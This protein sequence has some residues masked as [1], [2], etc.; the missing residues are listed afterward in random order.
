MKT[1][2]LLLAVLGNYFSYMP[3][4]FSDLTVTAPV[5]QQAAAAN[6][7]ELTRKQEFDAALA[8]KADTADMETALADKADTADVDASLAEKLAKASNLGDLE[9]AGAARGNLELGTAAVEDIGTGVGEVVVGGDPRLEDSRTP[10]DHADSHKAGGGDELLLNEMGLPDG[11]VAMNGQ[12]LTGLADPIAAQDGTTVAWVQSQDFN[13]P[14]KASARVA[15]LGNITLAGLG[16]L[17]GV[18]LAEGDRVLTMG[19]TVKSQNG[20][21]LA[22][23]GAW[24]R[25]TDADTSAKFSK[26]MIVRINEGT[27]LAGNF[28]S[29]KTTGLIT[30]GTTLLEF[31]Q[32]SGTG[33]ILAGA[34]IS[35]SGNTISVTDAGITDAKIG[36][37]TVDD[38]LATPASTGPLSSLLS[39]I[40]GRIKAI[41]GTTHWYDAP[42][43][44]LAEADAAITTVTDDLDAYITSN[45]AAMAGK[46]GAN[47]EDVSTVNA[48][49][50]LGL[51]TAAGAD[52]GTADGEVVVG[53][54]TRLTDSRTPTAH[55]ESHKLD[56]DD[57]ILL[58]EMGL[59]TAPVAMNSQKITG[60]ADG[61]N[62]QDGA[63]VNNVQEVRDEVGFR[64]VRLISTGNLALT[65]LVAV[66]GVTPAA[67]ELVGAIN[68]T[69]AHQNG[70]YIVG[71][72]AWV[73]TGDT[74]KAGLTLRATEG[75]VNAG[76]SFRVTTNGPITVG[77][78]A[79][80]F[81]ENEGPGI[82][83][84]RAGGL[85]S[86]L[87][88]AGGQVVVD[89]IYGDDSTGARGRHD[90]PFLTLTAAKAASVAG[91]WI[92]VGPGL[93]NETDLA[94]DQVNWFF[95]PG[96]VVDYSGASIVGI[97]ESTTTLA[98]KVRGNGE[99]IHRAWHTININGATAGASTADIECESILATVAGGVG[100]LL[101][102]TGNVRVKCRTISAPGAGGAGVYGGHGIVNIEAESITGYSKGVYMLGSLA[103]VWTIKADTIAAT[104]SA[105]GASASL[106]GGTLIVTARELLKAVKVGGLGAACS[107]TINGARIVETSV[108][109]PAISMVAAPAL[110]VLKD[111]ILVSAAA[112]SIDSTA[113]TNVKVYGTC[114]ANV[115]KGSNITEIV[116]TIEVDVD[117]N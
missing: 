12:R 74:L 30:L 45:D 60:L 69:T 5:V 1:L 9:D 104:T 62:P 28:Y 44:T 55:A 23:A 97:F 113:A 94:K 102:T 39:W 56:G 110:T 106:F 2:T 103:D 27:T 35:K 3:N 15:A 58:S 26:G 36:D 61:E 37:R 67:G 86:S 75:T 54:D 79:V 70:P 83:I 32:F 22:S 80:A 13:G 11:P 57:E 40:A 76:R 114:N 48:W 98:F 16:T 87:I 101:G 66:D 25:A 51:G 81:G 99:F 93:Y 89:A 107:L 92:V 112:T 8:A 53:G 95:Q 42:A 108:T 72:G 111:V 21:R 50:N 64:I 90:R 117:V 105:T 78:T 73:R 43:M 63:T 68:Q 6:P 82:G 109:T 100:V 96:A 18:T 17:D 24:S 59:P 33:I 49:A 84:S 46:M 31:E 91:D 29:L 77:T 65:G 19:Q 4:I 115:V 52:V 88:Y 20:L 41:T 14:V 71:A 34:G 10:T 47:L 7:N 38:T 85:V 116:G